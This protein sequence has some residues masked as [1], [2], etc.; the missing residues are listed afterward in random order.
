MKWYIYGHKVRINEKGKF[1]TILHDEG[2]SLIYYTLS[3]QKMGEL[4]K[5]TLVT[6]WFSVGDRVLVEGKTKSI[7]RVTPIHYTFSDNTILEVKEQTKITKADDP[8]LL[9]EEIV[10]HCN[11]IIEKTNND[12]SEH[13]SAYK[14][15]AKAIKECINIIAKDYLRQEVHDYIERHGKQS[16]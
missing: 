3:L 8:K 2:Q 1:Y 5:N 6:K 16:H 12:S 15:S 7:T 13:S 14:F 4:L 9:V 10:N 11:S